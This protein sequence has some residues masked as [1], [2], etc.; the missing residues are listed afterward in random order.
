[1]INTFYTKEKLTK[2]GISF[3]FLNVQTIIQVFCLC[4]LSIAAQSQ[5]RSDTYLKDVAGPTDLPP[6]IPSV[7]EFDQTLNK[8]FLQ[9]DLFSNYEKSLMNLYSKPFELKDLQVNYN[10]II[11]NYRTGVES[12]TPIYWQQFQFNTTW[13]I[14]GMPFS[15]GLQSTDLSSFSINRSAFPKLQFQK[16]AYLNNIKKAVSQQFDPSKL[17]SQLKN[18]YTSFKAYAEQALQAEL[19]EL[20]ENYGKALQLP[21]KEFGSFDQLLATDPQAI[22][23]KLLNP[24]LQAKAASITQQLTDIQSRINMGE[25]IDTAQLSALLQ[26][27]KELAGIQKLV[28]K[29]EAHKQS[30]QNSGLVTKLKEWDVFK[31][32]Q[33]LAFLKKPSSLS[34]LSKQYLSLNGIQR[35]FLK[36]NKL[37]AGQNTVST[38]PLSMNHFMNNGLLTE[39]NKGKKDLTFFLGSQPSVQSLL[40]NYAGNIEGLRTKARAFQLAGT[41]SQSRIS[42]MSFSESFDELLGSLNPSQQLRQTLITTINKAFQV[43]SKGKLTTEISRSVT[44]YNG[45]RDVG[46]QEEGLKELLASDDFFKNAAFNLSYSDEYPKADLSYSARFKK[47]ANGYANPGSAFLN[48]GSSEVGFFIKKAFLK[49]KLQIDLRTDAREYK[50]N[51]VLDDK[52]R[53]VYSVLNLRWK[54]R[55]NQTLTLRYQPNQ[56]VRIAG[57]QKNTFSRF[58][59][60]SADINLMKKNRLFSYFNNSSLS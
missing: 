11:T 52:W 45:K 14:I 21:I 8:I 51:D 50:Y 32:Q 29:L 16:E 35:F 5:L 19:K 57:D 25:S 39:I 40:N 49:R 18:P 15:I 59:R 36:V 6:S 60:L 53:N 3:C 13:N 34:H 7:K 42:V 10:G 22:R 46:S 56:M 2:K 43:G 20:T 12:Y 27:Q 41:N 17:E 4:L 33:L 48:R 28:E 30:W 23:R 54:I 55:K 31:K 47:V 1:M 9:P 24:E 26:S 37:N 44:Q 58:D 38:S